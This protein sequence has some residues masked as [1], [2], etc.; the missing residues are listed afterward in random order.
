MNSSASCAAVRDSAAPRD[1]SG[2]VCPRLLPTRAA[3]VHHP[4]RQ[5]WRWQDLP[6]PPNHRGFHQPVTDWSDLIRPLAQAVG[7][8]WP[9]N[10]ADLTTDHLLSA[11]GDG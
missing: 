2:A 9:A 10:E 5:R 1:Q 11:A 6:L 8:Q 7:A 3:T 4:H